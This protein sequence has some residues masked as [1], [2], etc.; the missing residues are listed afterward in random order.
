MLLPLAH[1]IYRF[2]IVRHDKLP[3][4]KT[5]PKHFAGSP[6]EQSLRSRRPA[7]HFE[8]VVPLD[9]RE[10]S[11]FDVKCETFVIVEGCCFEEFAVGNVADDCNAADYV[12][13]LVVAWRVITFKETMTSALRNYVRTILR[14]DTSAG[15][16]FAIELVFTGLREAVEDFKRTLP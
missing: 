8:F 11:V 10:R 7:Q 13:V 3:I 15:Q 12:A 16:R 5:L 1:M 9:D 6:A 2:E 14:D 4:V